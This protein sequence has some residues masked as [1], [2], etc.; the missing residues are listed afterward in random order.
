MYGVDD[1]ENK[2]KSCVLHHAINHT[3]YLS[4]KD[5]RG[6]RINWMTMRNATTGETLWESIN[7]WPEWP[8]ADNLSDDELPAIKIPMCIL[9]CKAVSRE[10]NFTSD[11]EIQNLRIQQEITLYGSSI[12]EWNFTFGFVIP[13]STNSW[14]QVIE[15][16][17]EDLMLD[18]DE[19]SGNCAIRSTFWDGDELI[20][21]SNVLL[22]YV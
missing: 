16:S 13:G 5:E 9:D 15:A 4:S 20:Y 17:D 14:Q 7:E 10:I 1:N 3:N 18:P 21:A 22:Y 2:R 6:F 11:K 12:E 19:L 8:K